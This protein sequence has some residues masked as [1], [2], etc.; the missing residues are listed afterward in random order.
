MNWEK[1]FPVRWVLRGVPSRKI[2]ADHI[3]KIRRSHGRRLAV[4]CL[5]HGYWLGVVPSNRARWR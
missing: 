5:R 3:R 2:F 4:K 1:L